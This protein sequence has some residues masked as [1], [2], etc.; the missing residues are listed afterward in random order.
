MCVLAWPWVHNM[1]ILLVV[2]IIIF[3]PKTKYAY[4]VYDTYILILLLL[5]RSWINIGISFLFSFLLHI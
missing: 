1:L 3:V 5:F 4:C 2:C